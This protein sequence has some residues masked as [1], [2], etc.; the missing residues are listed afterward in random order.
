M[1]NLMLLLPLMGL[2]AIQDILTGIFGAPSI[3][4]TM[5]A[6]QAMGPRRSL[7]FSAF[8]QLIGPFLFGVA[9][10][11]TIGSEVADSFGITPG[12]LYAAL[13]ATI[14]WMV[15]TWFLSI[16]C[17]ST[18]ALIGGLVGA[19]VIG[20]GPSSIHLIG[21]LKIILSLTLT[22]PLALIV[23]FIV[24]KISASVAR[25]ETPH[26]NHRFNRGQLVTSVFLGLAIGSNNAQNAMG[27][28]TL[29]LMATGSLSKFEVPI[30]VVAASAICLALGNLIGGTRLIRSV[31]TQFFN[32][33]PIHGF[34]AGV[35]SA[36]IIL[37]SSLVGG[38]VSTSHVTSM[39]I[40]GA[41][42][43]ENLSEVQWI[44]VRKVLLTWVLTI[45]FTGVLAGV[46]Y[47]CF[48]ALGLH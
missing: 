7:I 39:S 4:A 5:I 33:R 36:T 28:T 6:S 9:V 12:I 38:D 29:G 30:W 45:P 23:G 35:S 18:H 26:V 34:C 27:I 47:L 1:H 3:V 25:H 40:V 11:S 10:A 13:S 2:V 37:V 31:G 43:A 41:G 16:P 21:L 8:V 24:T 42:A 32:I 20:L 14:F 19:V 48:R 22:A 46:L 15:F 17:S 44:F